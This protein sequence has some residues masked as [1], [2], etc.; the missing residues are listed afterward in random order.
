[1]V[2]ASEQRT[3]RRFNIEIPVTVQVNDGE[4]IEGMTRDVSARGV[5]IR[6]DADLKEDS[7]LEF[8]LTLPAEITMTRS[9]QVQCTG[10]V[11]RVAR[12]DDGPLGV[13]A[14]IDNY[15]F[16]PEGGATEATKL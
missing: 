6:M 9:V 8:T 1:M 5:F 13:V 11:L 3:I 15:R 12:Q 14:M 7:P 2:D 4:T 16:I 10:R